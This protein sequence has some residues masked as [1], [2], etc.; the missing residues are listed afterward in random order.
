M[1]HIEDLRKRDGLT[2]PDLAE[3]IG[4]CESIV[5]DWERNSVEIPASGLMALKEVFG[6]SVDYLLGFGVTEMKRT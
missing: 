6:V 4:V 5:R 1:N 3:K 2:V